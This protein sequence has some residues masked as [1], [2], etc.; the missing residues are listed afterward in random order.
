M[1]KKG[2]FCAPLKCFAEVFWLIVKNKELLFE[3]FIK[4]E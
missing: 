4:L 3:N 2:F 1:G